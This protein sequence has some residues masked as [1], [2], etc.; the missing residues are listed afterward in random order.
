MMTLKQAVLA[1]L[2][3]GESHDALLDLIHSHQS[4]GLAAEEAYDTL[5]Q[6]WLEFGFDQKD[7]GGTLR[8]NLEWVMEKVWFGPP[9]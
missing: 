6:I 7:D 2:S 1:A 3:S 5:E 4:Q 8:E 9:A